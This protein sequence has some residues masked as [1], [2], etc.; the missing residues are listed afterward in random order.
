MV[1]LKTLKLSIF[2]GY[3]CIFS[4]IRGTEVKKLERHF[5]SLILTCVML[6]TL[7]LWRVRL[8]ELINLPK[9]LLLA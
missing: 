1:N 4:A 8:T 6:P 5:L 3:P 9:M 2:R 7:Y